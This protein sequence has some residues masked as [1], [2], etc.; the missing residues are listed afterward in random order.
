MSENSITQGV[1]RLLYLLMFRYISYSAAYM[2]KSGI[3]YYARYRI[4][5]TMA[6]F[7]LWEKVCVI[8]NK[9]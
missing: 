8:V 9:Y 2:L 6:Q 4:G 3:S 7:I 1:V 5:N